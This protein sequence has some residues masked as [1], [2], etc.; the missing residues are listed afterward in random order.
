[1]FPPGANVSTSKVLTGAQ[2]GPSGSVP[3]S[4][5]KPFVCQFT[6]LAVRPFLLSS[7]SVLPRSF[8]VWSLVGLFRSSLLQAKISLPK[9]PLFG[10][11]PS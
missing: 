10:F 2:H 4:S 5:T 8:F 9:A 11:Y 7:L 1:M 3:P 6:L